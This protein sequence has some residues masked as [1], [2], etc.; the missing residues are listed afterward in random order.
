MKTRASFLLASF[1]LLSTAHAETEDEFATRVSGYTQDVELAKPADGAPGQV[2]VGSFR[3]D[4]AKTGALTYKVPIEAVP[5]RGGIAPDIS[6][7]YSSQAGNGLLGMGWSL[8][9]LPAITRIRFERPIRYDGKDAYAVSVGVGAAPVAGGRLVAAGGKYH[10]EDES[11][12]ELVPEGTCGDGPCAWTLRDGTGKTY[13]FGASSDA[14]YWERNGKRGVLVWA[15]SRVEDLKGN[16]YTVSYDVDEWTLYPTSAF[17]GCSD[18]LY[19]SPLL[20]PCT[21]QRAVRFAYEARP[22]AT[23]APARFVRRL[24]RIE[25]AG[26]SAGLVR[27]IRLGYEAS[28]VTGR[29]RL[30]SIEELGSDAVAALPAQRFEYTNGAALPGANRTWTAG[31]TG[32]DGVE[33]LVGDINGDGFDDVVR[34][35]S[36]VQGRAVEYALGGLGGLGGLVQWSRESGSY[37][38]WHA[39]LVD[40][41]ADG[42]D[43]LVLW[44]AGYG[45][46]EVR[47]HH[48]ASG[49]LSPT[50]TTYS[51]NAGLS[52]IVGTDVPADFRM[53]AGDFNG[54]G[55]GDLA[56]V[57]R[58]RNAVGLMLGSTSGLRGVLRPAGDMLAPPVTKTGPMVAD[59][60]GDGYQDLLLVLAQKN[61]YELVTYTGHPGG[62]SD[63]RRVP[64]DLGVG[65]DCG[66]LDGQLCYVG[67][68][69]FQPLTGDQDADGVDDLLLSYTGKADPTESVFRPYRRDLRSL[70][71]RADLDGATALHLA[72]HTALNTNDF[73]HTIDASR[74]FWQSALGDV[75]GDGLAD[76][77]MYYSGAYGRYVQSALG[78]SGGGHGPIVDVQGE[79]TTSAQPDGPPHSHK[80]RSRVADLDGDGRADLLT[81]YAGPAGQHVRVTFGTEAGLA[82]SAQVFASL[83]EAQIA[84]ASNSADGSRAESVVLLLPDVNGDGKPDLVLST[85][86]GFSAWTSTPGSSDLLAAVRNGYGGKV[87]VD[88][89]SAPRVANAVL[90]DRTQCRS[91]ATCGMA[92]RARRP[93]ATAVRVQD[94]RQRAE[95][96]Y[97]QYLNGRVVPGPVGGALTSR[98][99]DLGFER[100]SKHDAMRGTATLT[101]LSQERPRQGRVTR[102]VLSDDYAAGTRLLTEEITAYRP[103]TTTLF[104]TSAVLVESRTRRTYEGYQLATEQQERWTYTPY[105]AVETSTECAD[106]VCIETRHDYAPPDLARYVVKRPS[107]I[108]KRRADSSLLLSWEAMSYANDLVVDRRRL[109]CYEAEDCY[110]FQGDGACV[111]AGRARW[112]EVER[113]HVYDGQGNLT[114]VT[115]A[116]GRRTTFS[117]DPGYKTLRA[118]TTKYLSRSSGPYT[119]TTRQTY[120]AAGRPRVLTDY[121]GKTTV[122]TYDPVGRPVRTDLPNGGY[123]TWVYV[124]QGDPAAQHVEHTRATSATTACSGCEPVVTALRRKSFFDGLGRTYRTETPTQGA[125]TVVARRETVPMWGGDSLRESRPYFASED[126]AQVL[127]TE[128]RF[129]Y[130]GRP[131]AE[132]KRRGMDLQTVGVDFGLVRRYTRRPGQLVVEDNAA[133][134]LADGRLSAM[135]RWLA[136]TSTTNQ[137]GLVTQKVDAEGNTTTYTYDSAFRPRGVVGPVAPAGRPSGPEQRITQSFD[138]FGRVVRLADAVLGETVFVLDDVGNRIGTRDAL[139]RYVKQAYDELDRLRT[140]DRVDAA[141]GRFATFTYDE[142]AVANGLGRLTTLE[143]AEARTH[144]DAYDALGNPLSRS[145]RMTGLPDELVERYQYDLAGRPTGLTYPDGASA[146]YTYHPEGPLDAVAS[147]GVWA[148][149][150]AYASNGRPGRRFL[151][152]KVVSTYGYNPDGNLGVLKTSNPQGGLVQSYQIGYDAQKNVLGIQDLRTSPVVGQVDTFDGWTFAYD[153]LSR[154]QGAQQVSRPGFTFR[155]DAQGNL[156]QKG[157]RTLVPEL[158]RVTVQERSAATGELATVATAVF[159][160]VG[161]LAKKVKPGESWVY[162]YDVDNRL[163]GVTRNGLLV[164]ELG[165]DAQGARV[166]QTAHDG[167]GA[168]TTYYPSRHYEVWTRDGAVQPVRNLEAL[169][170]G[171][172]AQVRGS[173]LPGAPSMSLVDGSYG[174]PLSA[175]TLHGMP[176]GTYYTFGNHLGSVSVVANETG[177]VTRY[178]YEPYGEVLRGRSTGTD[179]ITH[180]FTDRQADAS[181]GLLYYGARYYD[182]ELG[183]FI[184]ADTVIPGAG[185]DPQGLNRYAYVLNNPLKLVDPSGHSPEEAT[186]SEPR[187]GQKKWS[188]LSPREQVYE[189]QRQKANAIDPSGGRPD[190]VALQKYEPS[191]GEQ[192]IGLVID[193]LTDGRS[194]AFGIEGRLSG[195]LGAAASGGVGLW[196]TPVEGL[197]EWAIKPVGGIGRGASASLSF[198]LCS[199][200]DGASFDGHFNEI[201]LPGPVGPVYTSSGYF[202]EPDGNWACLSYSVS[203]GSFV[204]A[205]VTDYQQV[206]R[207]PEPWWGTMTAGEWA[208]YGN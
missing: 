172:V 86:A 84:E 78:Q 57:S 205:V 92:N 61:H 60:N 111:A 206:H 47:V 33:T 171:R 188:E 187:V 199:A 49:G 202:G 147:G 81:Y 31:R 100:V 136:T 41:N 179:V 165:Y 10:T 127:W 112:V 4:V 142:V 46:A 29:S 167:A 38:G 159:D 164:A 140:R 128:T 88:H 197:A 40:V 89:Q 55:V 121:N 168:T 208:L 109:L 75:N 189:S 34:V 54:D 93:L 158:R 94:G 52:R 122:R 87:E 107:A 183:R 161:N 17:Y 96:L 135:S 65:A 134:V 36:D 59:V 191:A 28:P 192:V 35:A 101:E 64:I 72:R 190:L 196:Y 74:A 152:T 23:A 51:D 106:G 181:T 156:I 175:D 149:F 32:L 102:T 50:A 30:V 143:N 16:K 58:R 14:R 99:A 77:V 155:Q 173:A 67:F 154:L 7:A 169:A 98:R 176:K 118:S 137:R 11:Y 180:K 82:Q 53:A 83:P 177:E 124:S 123:E 151:D 68:T 9:G 108:R 130:E 185:S 198:G 170:W 73:V 18:R 160:D 125:R 138:S 13:T 15:L 150:D 45:W 95:T 182:P 22:D 39:L 200:K 129:D 8:V 186:I 166:R 207:A 144:V 85:H 105:G 201:A 184:T 133:E 148:R 79:R 70:L 163:T 24:S 43:D 139:G 141:P 20:R 63:G 97:Y 37:A 62:L 114:E 12:S 157:A 103:T 6:L 120:D 5:G 117:Y 76:L 80:W 104:G 69:P 178:V 66:Q 116:L 71:G 193:G 131:A 27:T 174:Q 3:W 115:D 48:G 195:G 110:C 1:S 56:L 26:T 2:P 203:L 19:L 119:L 42:R 194:F 44:F 153:G 145:T 91:A 204:G 126:A 162:T 113:G 25:V 90:P 21:D 146:V 132:R